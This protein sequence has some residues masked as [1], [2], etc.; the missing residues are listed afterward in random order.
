MARENI[1]FYEYDDGSYNMVDLY[2]YDK[3]GIKILTIIMILMLIK[4]WYIQ[5]V[6]MNML[7]D[8]MMYIK[9]TL[10]HYN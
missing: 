3:L 2:L 9:G 5:K 10:Y 4:Y 7:F 1:N 6:I 8:I